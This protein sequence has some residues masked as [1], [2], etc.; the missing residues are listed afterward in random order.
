MLSVFHKAGLLDPIN[1]EL[2]LPEVVDESKWW[3]GK[4]PFVDP[5][6]KYIFAFNGESVSNYGLQHEAR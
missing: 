5:E 4:H 1:S 2:I 6:G 3:K